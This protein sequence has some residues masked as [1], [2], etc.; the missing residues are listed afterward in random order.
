[1]FFF[2]SSQSCAYADA[3]AQPPPALFILL[4]TSFYVLGSLFP[5]STLQIMFPRTAPPPAHRE[6]PEGKEYTEALEQELQ[7]LDVVK[8]LR[9]QVEASD[10][11]WYE[12]RESRNILSVAYP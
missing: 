7:G 3:C 2:R 8:Q 9:E 4:P 6:S 5:P 12:H 11:E 1:M 10:G